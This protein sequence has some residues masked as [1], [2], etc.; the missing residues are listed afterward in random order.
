MENGQLQVA[1]T[2]WRDGN[3]RRP[4]CRCSGLAGLQQRI[5][6]ICP[7]RARD[8]HRRVHVLPIILIMRP[9]STRISARL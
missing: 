9:R 5:R 1:L 6:A 2:V 7:A 4:Q 3:L 8:G